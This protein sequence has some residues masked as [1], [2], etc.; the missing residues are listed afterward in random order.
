MVGGRD[1]ERRSRGSV[2]DRDCDYEYPLGAEREA[3]EADVKQ[4]ECLRCGKCAAVNWTKIR[5]SS[6]QFPRNAGR[7]VRNHQSC[8]PLGPCSAALDDRITENGVSPS[9]TKELGGYFQQI[10]TSRL[11]S[12]AFR[13]FQL[14]LL[15]PLILVKYGS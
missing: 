9:K 2:N 1:D 11:R 13:R 6:R 12:R 15:E 5:L 7:K 4:E 3:I 10:Y 14:Q 8:P